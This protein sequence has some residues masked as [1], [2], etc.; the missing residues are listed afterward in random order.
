MWT[1]DNIFYFCL[2]MVL[3]IWSVMCVYVGFRLGCIIAGHVVTP[4]IQTKE[5][6]A[7]MT[8]EDPYYKPMYGE[9]QPRIQTVPG[10]RSK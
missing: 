8:D 1:A 10:E 5:S 6:K 4:L 7:I 9:E 2:I 3:C